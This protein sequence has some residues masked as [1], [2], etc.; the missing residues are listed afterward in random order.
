MK[1]KT[2]HIL[3]FLVLIVGVTIMVFP[4]ER[5]LVPIYMQSGMLDKARATLSHLLTED[6]NDVGALKDASRL[7]LLLG[8]P[9]KGIQ[10]LRRAALLQPDNVPLLIELAKLYEWSR[11]TDQAMRAWE[12]ISELDPTEPKA[13]ARLIGYYRYQGDLLKEAG[14]VSRLVL[15]QADAPRK[16]D[17]APPFIALL[18]QQMA[19][20]ARQRDKEP[21]DLLLSALL[22]GLYLIRRQYAL[23]TEHVADTN[24]KAVALQ[25][26]VNQTLSILV[27]TD[28]VQRAFNVAAQVD[29]ADRS[30]VKTRLAL[31]RILTWSGMRKQ[32]FTLASRLAKDYP[33]NEQIL[34]TMAR[35]GKTTEQLDAAIAAYERLMEKD[36]RRIDVLQQ[37]ADVC[38]QANQPGKAY[39]LYRQ[40]A[41]RAPDNI[42]AIER[43]L[44][45]AQFSGDRAIGIQA[46][47]LAGQLRPDDPGITRMRADLYLAMGDPRQAFPLYRDLAVSTGSKA[48]V[49]KMIE[50]ARY[51]GD[52]SFVSSAVQEALRRRPD[53]PEVM[54]TAAELYLASD[55]PA[56]ANRLYQKLAASSGG[57]PKIVLDMLRTA[58]YTGDKA[59]IGRSLD[60]ALGLCPDHA[61]VTREAAR[62]Y[63]WIDRPD[64]AYAMERRMVVRF[65]GGKEAVDRMLKAAEY[66]GQPHILES[67]LVLAAMPL[68]RDAALQRR[69]ADAYL[70]ES[71]PEKAIQAFVR[72]LHL[73]PGDEAVQQKLAKVYL[74]NDA[75]EKAYAIYA[76]LYRKHPDDPAVV[77]R[78]LELAS[79][80]GRGKE[81]ARIAGAL[82]DA[83]P[84]DFQKALDAGEAFIAAGELDAGIGFLDRASRLKPGQTDLQR[85]L[86]TLYGWAGRS[87]RQMEQLAHL[88]EKGLLT[89]KER[90][91]L[92][93]AYLDHRE[94]AKV[95]A[96]LKGAGDDRRPRL[97]EAILLATAYELSGDKDRAAR[98][99]QRLAREHEDDPDV[100]A[101]LGNR[102]LWLN[103]V[104]LA[105]RF[106]NA[107]LMKDPRNLAALKGSAQIYAW[108]NDPERAIRRFEH[109]NRLDPKDYEAYYQLGELYFTNDR[110]G[111]AYKAYRKTMK[112]IQA[113]RKRCGQEPQ[114]ANP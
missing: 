2:W 75:P 104:G 26:A 46:A 30:G 51:T 81:A 20:L 64:R 28:Q 74:W 43:M 15:L 85:R 87:D 18:N 17:A 42:Y 86:A 106:Y 73:K 101:D 112:L 111:D 19:E 35:L 92:A 65:G 77:N 48:D 27:Q 3:C 1:V 5:S 53:D 33:D 52:A 4:T 6:P 58:G 59:V 25:R 67:A 34:L 49:E 13:W 14:A 11:E 66:T 110:K 9:E 47:Q 24:E 32:A 78:L 41:A 108:N 100:L 71:Q 29:R 16:G 31:I 91:T 72:Y 62:M 23:S 22:S 45:A 102:A 107:A 61:G 55:N 105:S 95:V 44:N 88:W 60:L 70:A 39:G 76:S 90:R 69:L 103:R 36:P 80:T 37:L 97:D 8:D 98:L 96:L 113:A 94:F 99:Y 57:D 79:W 7:Y 56:A 83:H 68:P 10:A 89:E 50:V 82:S 40:I 12:R 109:Y 21:D 54:K 63:L 84:R 93:Q 114:T 38:M